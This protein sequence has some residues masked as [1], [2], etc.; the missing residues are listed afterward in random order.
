MY[1]VKITHVSKD[2][3]DLEGEFFSVFIDERKDMLLLFRD[4]TDKYSPAEKVERYAIPMVNIESLSIIPLYEDNG[5]K[6]SSC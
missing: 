1:K 3:S 2:V 4:I 6:V 5:Q